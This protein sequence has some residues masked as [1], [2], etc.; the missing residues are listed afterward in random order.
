MISKPA[1]VSCEQSNSVSISENDESEHSRKMDFEIIS[2]TS[3]SDSSESTSLEQNESKNMD[4]SSEGE[5]SA[6]DVPRDAESEVNCRECFLPKVS[7]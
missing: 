6:E 3:G 5:M 4:E 1:Q 2:E 7:H